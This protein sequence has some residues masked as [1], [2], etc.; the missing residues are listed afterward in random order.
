MKKTAVI[1]GAGE[2][3]GVALARRF[4]RE[5]YRIA[6]V[7]RSVDHLDRHCARLR[8]AGVEAKGY[9]ADLSDLDAIPGLFDR[10][11]DDF[12]TVD[13]LVFNAA[14]A[15][16]EAGTGLAPEDLVRDFAVSV[17]SAHAATLAVHDDVLAASGALLYTGGG[18][19]LETNPDHL[20]LSVNKAALRSLALN[21]HAALAGFGVEVGTV[22]IC[23]HIAP[24]TAFDPDR[25]ADAFWRLRSGEAGPEIVFEG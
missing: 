6:L 1:L 2:G 12:V 13:T 10:I 5:G 9:A 7:A 24:G 25:I 11:R 22:T 14:S 19:A 16:L 20:T 21:W 8:Q 4:G 3:M 23:G 15:H 17:A 18:A